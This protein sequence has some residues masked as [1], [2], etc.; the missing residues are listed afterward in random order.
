[1]ITW[2]DKKVS[3]N[4]LSGNLTWGDTYSQV[5][6]RVRLRDLPQVGLTQTTWPGTMDQHSVPSL[7]MDDEA[8]N[9]GSSPMGLWSGC[10]GQDTT[11]ISLMSSWRVQDSRTEQKFVWDSQHVP[12]TFRER[13][14]PLM[15]APQ[16]GLW[17]VWV[18]WWSRFIEIVKF[19][20]HVHVY[21]GWEEMYLRWPLE[22][23]PWSI[24]LPKFDT[25]TLMIDTTE[26][27]PDTRTV[28]N[29]WLLLSYVFS[30]PPWGIIFI[31]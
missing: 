1:M 30:Q 14:I 26:Y 29:T 11:T 24:K 9:A 28:P 23:G 22:S 18:L 19:C 27:P 31:L 2:C 13:R 7:M 6:S 8:V 15:G 25:V 3:L 5:L 16:N 17:I 12:E 4:G 10:E 20:M 21:L